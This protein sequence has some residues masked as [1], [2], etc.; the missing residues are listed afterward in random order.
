MTGRTYNLLSPEEKKMAWDLYLFLA[1]GDSQHKEWLLEAI[2]AFFVG[3]V[4]PP[5][6]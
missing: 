6:R 4:R 3:D 5:V 1:H 2:E